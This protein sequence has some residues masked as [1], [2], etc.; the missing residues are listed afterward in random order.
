VPVLGADTATKVDWEEQSVRT[1]VPSA[2]PTWDDARYFV[3]HPMSS[4]NHPF[5]QKDWSVVLA[6]VSKLRR[7]GYDSR[8][9]RGAM[10]AFYLQR[11]D[12]AHEHPAY[13]FSR[14]DVI[15]RLMSVYD[16]ITTDSVTKFLADGFVR[17]QGELPWHHEDDA[18]IR[19]SLL[20]YGGDLPY[21][22][23]EIVIELLVEFGDSHGE[24]NSQLRYVNDIVQ[25]N[26]D[27][28]SVLPIKEYV[29]AVKVVLPT[30]LRS[31]RKS[32]LSIRDAAPTLQEAVAHLLQ[33]RNRE[34]RN[35]HRLEK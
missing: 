17:S 30:E 25:W 15:N 9:I 21:R 35:A 19:R 29:K 20:T 22:Y 6:V 2:N 23:P 33:R 27:P 14:I 12:D 10:N 31:L 26:L 28:Y 18:D 16:P 3:Y 5:S 7:R 11:N 34:L 13:A 4:L 32:R 24:L 8:A 1:F